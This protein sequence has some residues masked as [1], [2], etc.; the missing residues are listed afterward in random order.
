MEFLGLFLRHHFV[1]K[2]VWEKPIV[3]SRNA[4]LAVSHP[5]DKK[6]LIAYVTLLVS[7]IVSICCRLQMRGALKLR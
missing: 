3:V 4:I 2:P 7:F 6:Q 5:R 1:Q